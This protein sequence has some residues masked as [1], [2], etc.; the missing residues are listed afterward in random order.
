VS[1]DQS[2]VDSPDERARNGPDALRAFLDTSLD[3]V[4]V[5]DRDGVIR[6]WNRIA[7]RVF[8]WSREEAIGLSLAET[9][10]PPEFREMHRMGLERYLA[11]GEER[12]LDRRLE[13]EAIDRAGHRFPVE[14]AIR[15]LRLPEGLHFVGFLRDARERRELTRLAL[16]RERR[17][18][19]AIEAT[20]AAFW[21]LTLDAW[22]LGLVAE[23]LVGDSVSTMLGLP[24]GAVP[25][26][27]PPLLRVIHPE[28]RAAVAEAWGSH[29]AGRSV[30][31]E[32]EHRRQGADGSW[33]WVL[34]RGS[35]VERY[36]DG[37]PRRVAGTVVDLT[38]RK[39]LQEA[40]LNA[41][42]L[43]AVGLVASGFAHDLNNILMAARGHASIGA[44]VP[45]VPPKVRSSLE[46]IQS[47]LAIA[48]AITQN[49]VAIGRPSGGG[50]ESIPVA[51]TVAKS[52]E[53][54]RPA[55]PRAMEVVFENRL[56][57]EV[58]VRIEPSR[59]QQVLMNLALNARDATAERGRLEILVERAGDAAEPRVRIVVRDNGRGI[60]AS[61]LPHLFEPFFTNKPGGRGTGLG[62]AVVRS[63]VESASGSIRVESEVGVGTAFFLEFPATEDLAAPTIASDAEPMGGQTERLVALVED[64]PLLRPMLAE[65]IA[66]GGYRVEAFESGEALVEALRAGL[67]PQLLVLDFNLP[68]MDGFAAREAASE[69]LG[70]RP[71]T[72][73][74]TGN[75]DVVLPAAGSEGATLLRKPFELGALLDGLEALRG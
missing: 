11:T 14:A 32:S 4:V 47:S 8:G 25:P 7:E 5:M 45:G 9:I 52:L 68:G 56:D 44:L 28:D 29:L 65:T 70:R 46:A 30:R 53:V 10:V 41:Q 26:L 62:L 67:R 75:P 59:F 64:H 55:F 2:Q 15:P 74:V 66:G 12:V 37:R 13:L 21:D 57:G 36:E 31:Y 19:L 20:G 6:G 33:R 58:T 51:T 23:S 61:D 73:F 72:L 69:L 38:E 71:P 43:D 18:A 48:R 34:D 50:S 42:K 63:V 40:V 3:P 60:P 24:P 16:E 49:M 27:P 22:G 54:L 1:V 17:L 39:R 35:V